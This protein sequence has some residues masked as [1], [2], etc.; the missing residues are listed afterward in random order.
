MVDKP[1]ACCTENARFVALESLFEHIEAR[2]NQFSPISTDW[3]C[4]QHAQTPRTR[5]LAIFVPTTTTDDCFT[6]CACAHARGVII[7]GEPERA[8]NT[9]GTGSGFIRII[10][11]SRPERA[12]H[13]RFFNV[14]CLYM[15]I[16]WHVGHA[17]L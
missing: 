6:P 8:P 14:Q 10:G 2:K 17:K 1:Q 13:K 12:P 15:Y 3:L 7:R 16:L 5:D 4:L 9:R 11:A